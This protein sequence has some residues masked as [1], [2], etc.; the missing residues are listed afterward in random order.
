MS[1]EFGEFGTR[2]AGSPVFSCPLRKNEQKPKTWIAIRLNDEDGR[3]VGWAE[4][5][6]VDS[7]GTAV[8]GFLDGKGYA[9]AEVAAG[10]CQVTFPGID[11]ADWQR[12]AR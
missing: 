11:A 12:E 5:R 6:V 2:E 3:P 10:I 9:R 4:Y 8:S 7:E 1:A